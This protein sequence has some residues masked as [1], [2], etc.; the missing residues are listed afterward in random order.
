M[1]GTD[2]LIRPTPLLHP[3]PTVILVEPQMGENIGA[4][5]RAMFNCGLLDLRL[6]RPRDGWPNPR[7][8]ASASGAD[9]VLENAQLFETTQEA[10]ADLSRVYAT[11][12][13]RRDMVKPVV[14]PRLAVAEMRGCA[15]RG[16]RFGILFGPERTGLSNDDVVMADAIL[17]IPLNPSF[18]S[19]NL[20][21]AVLLISYEWYSAEAPE[22]QE[23]ELPVA[24]SWPATAGEVDNFLD[25]METE[26]VD[27]GFLYPE[28]KRPIMVRNLRN[29]FRRARLTDQEVR[30]LHGVVRALSGR[31]NRRQESP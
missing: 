28:E 18:S 8:T 30:T 29:I 24:G 5:A 20:G 3:G 6:V 31:R 19:L 2:H 14:A 7:A 12:A 23:R 13:R 15:E 25:R 1:A 22:K 16:E 11:S 27:A 26:L 17:A 10:V 21:Q 4:A 9:P